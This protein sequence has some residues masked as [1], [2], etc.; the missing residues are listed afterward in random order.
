MLLQRVVFRYVF[1]CGFSF[2]PESIF[3]VLV[4]GILAFSSFVLGLFYLA[5]VIS[6]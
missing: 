1:R 2:F 3:M 5:F 4:S 6:Y